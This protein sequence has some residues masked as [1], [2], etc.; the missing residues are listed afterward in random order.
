MC[1][2]VYN[3]YIP[4]HVAILHQGVVTIIHAMKVAVAGVTVCDS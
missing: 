2:F 1:N 4:F 3:N